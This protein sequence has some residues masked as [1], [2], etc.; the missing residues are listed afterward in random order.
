MSLDPDEL[1]A[2]LAGRRSVRTFRDDPPGED[3]IRRLVEA[4]VTAPSASNKQPWR[5]VVVQDRERIAALA[6]AVRAAVASLSERVEPS[7]AQAIA[8]YGSYFWR[9]EAAPVL[10]VPLFRRLTLLSHFL[11]AG[12]G[13]E[14]ASEAKLVERLEVRSG[15]IGT[16]LAIQ[17]L[18][19]MAHALGL[20]ASGMTGP[21]VAE[22]ALREQLSLPKSWDIACLIPIGWPAEEPTPTPRKPI[23]KVIRWLK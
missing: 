12:Q 19:L 21:L 2:V 1:Y 11:E 22:P 14:D 20:G 7:S 17:N 8:G 13:P 15:L 3:L 16:S 6:D 18:L 10:I 23:D 5:F 4:A 9:F